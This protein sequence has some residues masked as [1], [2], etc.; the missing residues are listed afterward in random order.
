MRI[1]DKIKLNLVVTTSLNPS[2]D[3]TVAAKAAALKLNAPF[4]IRGAT[5][6]SNIKDE[7]QAEAVLVMSQ[8][9]P[10]VHTDDGK[11]FF[12]LS[13]AE[14]RIKNVL[15]GKDD[16]MAEAMGLSLGMSVL[17]CTLGLGTDAIVASYLTGEKGRVV[18]LESSPL[19]ALITGEG[20]KD[21]LPP[22]DELNITGALR[23]IVVKNIDY[24]D[25]LTALAAKSFDIVYFDPM[26]RRPVHKSSNFA[27]FRALA[28][29]RPLI[30]EAVREACRVATGRVVMKETKGSGQFEKLGFL[31]ICGGKYSS[32][33]Y[34]VIQL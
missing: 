2:R 26:F 9:K 17:D 30:A 34:G 1:G 21:F 12:H 7:Y 11:Y 29:E 27:P 19:V 24:F 22:G 6:L 33:E 28:D 25:C 3:I 5:S 10:V 8:D 20:F 23:R 16:H 32:V 18:G 14:M 15:N 13:M 4:K 31:N